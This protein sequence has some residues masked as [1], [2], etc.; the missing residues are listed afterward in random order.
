M[1][2]CIV[3]PWIGPSQ[4]GVHLNLGP[5]SDEGALVMH[6]P[7]L[8][9]PKHCL[10]LLTCFFLKWSG[11]GTFWLFYFQAHPPTLIASF[12]TCFYHHHH[13]PSK[14]YMGKLLV[15]YLCIM[16]I[17]GT[18]RRAHVVPRDGWS[19]FQITWKLPK[20]YWWG[21]WDQIT[22]LSQSKTSEQCLRLLIPSFAAPQS[23]LANLIH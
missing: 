21:Q 19:P 4:V 11:S 18:L 16:F 23:P 20:F 13:H 10:L 6:N 3:K 9:L 17:P 5:G 1:W 2:I 7:T 22:H 14:L 15:S 8:N 12:H